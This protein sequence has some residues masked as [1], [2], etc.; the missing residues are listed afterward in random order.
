MTRTL[1]EVDRCLC[2][3]TAYYFKGSS[4]TVTQVKQTHCVLL[5]FFIGV[6]LIK[7]VMAFF[8]VVATL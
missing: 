7:F 1:I 8:F 2:L 6:M 4:Q 5:A 3:L